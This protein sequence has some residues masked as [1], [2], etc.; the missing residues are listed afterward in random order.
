MTHAVGTCFTLYVSHASPLWL[1]L[2]VG[3]DHVFSRIGAGHL[4]I[5]I[6]ADDGARP[7]S[8][9]NRPFIDLSRRPQSGAPGIIGHN[10]NVHRCFSFERKRILN[11]YFT[12][13][14]SC[15]CALPLAGSCQGQALRAPSFDFHPSDLS[16]TLS[17]RSV[18]SLD[19][20]FDDD[21]CLSR[22]LRSRPGPSELRWL[23]ALSFRI[24]QPRCPYADQN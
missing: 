23:S 3:P 14:I 10:V 12:H 11:T 21:V 5:T 16:I 2:A 17:C 15:C 1:S 20:L 22:S 7:V 13:S 4:A 6:Q 8:F 18:A 9:N 24:Q 19:A